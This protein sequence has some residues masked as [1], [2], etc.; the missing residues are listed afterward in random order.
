MSTTPVTPPTPKDV[1]MQDGPAS[2]LRF[3]RAASTGRGPTVLL[4]PS[5]I[6]RW[7]VLD[8]FPGSS[9]AE[10]LV[11]AGFDTFCLDWGVSGDEDRYLT[12]DDVVARLGRAVRKVR[13]LVGGGPLGMLG[14]CVGGTLAT[15]HTALHP[16]SVDALVNLAGPIDFAKGGM[17]TELVNP[18]WFDPEAIGAAGNLPPLQMQAGFVALRPT[19]DMGKILRRFE[20]LGDDSDGAA[21]NDA[22]E[23]WAGDNV[24][25]PGAA[26]GTYIKALYQNNELFEGRHHIAGERVDLAR[27][28]CPLLTV[29]TS[30]D[31]ICPPPAALALEEKVGTRDTEVLEIPGGHVGAVVGGRAQTMLYPKLAEWFGDK[32]TAAVRAAE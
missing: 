27:I 5:I 24:P 32:L 14:Y 6:N 1:V 8:L 21:R 2:L 18:R 17:L 31:T 4:V 9:V 11:N 10:A 12:W 19:A 22:L 23:A 25:F 26:Y 7:Y 30:R 29:V 15:I 20:R 13:R 28:D 3:R 16:E